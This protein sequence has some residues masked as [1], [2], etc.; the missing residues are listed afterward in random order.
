MLKL[1]VGESI[2]NALLSIE[3]NQ[4]TMFS[5]ADRGDPRKR[6]IIFVI[7]CNDALYIEGLSIKHQQ[8]KVYPNV[9]TEIG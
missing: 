2:E 1:K 4:T 8:C 3:S 9:K 6:F 7:K 5:R